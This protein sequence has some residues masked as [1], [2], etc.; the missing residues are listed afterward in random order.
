MQDVVSDIKV[1]I[2]E[3]DFDSPIT[4]SLGTYSGLDYLVVELITSG[5]IIG[6]GYTMS[7]DRRGTKAVL[8]YVSNELLPIIRGQNVSS[9]EKLWFQLWS[10]NKVRMRGGVGVHALSAVDMAVWDAN[11]KLKNLSLNS[12]LG[13]TKQKVEVYGSGGWLSMQDSELIDEAHSYADYG[14]QAYKFK[15]GGKRDKERT[16]LLRNEMGDNFALYTDA[17]QNFSVENAIETSNWLADFNVAWLEE[18]VLADCSWDLECVA[19]KSK[20]PIAAGE[21]VYFAWGFYD[22]CT[23][24]AASYLQPDAGRCG[25]ITEWIKIAELANQYNLRLTSHLLHEVS[26]SLIAAYSCGYLVE[27]MNLLPENPFTHDF[28]VK[29]GEILLPDAPGHGV[30]FT[31]EARKR[32]AA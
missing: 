11:A 31:S 17:N 6:Y 4:S 30:E 8:S 29:N 26:I 19:S 7:L 15:I 32:H 27:F 5:G 28:S 9:P 24:K 1:S 13:G 18:P 20:V 2:L 25:G 23:R 16:S 3:F 12:I 22:L 10:P 14:I 21:N